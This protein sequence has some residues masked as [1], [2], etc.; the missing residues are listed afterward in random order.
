M[1]LQIIE[2]RFLGH[3]NRSQVTT[4]TELGVNFTNNKVNMSQ[5]TL[6]LCAPRDVSS[7]QLFTSLS[8]LKAMR[9]ASYC[10]C[11][12]HREDRYCPGTVNQPR[13]SSLVLNGIEGTN[14]SHLH[15]LR[16]R[17]GSHKRALMPHLARNSL[18]SRQ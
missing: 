8:V 11:S 12:P 14:S 4:V 13:A 9:F 2:S 16:S 7:T 10:F 5:Q 17:T 1:I 15:K 3:P 6:K 18:T